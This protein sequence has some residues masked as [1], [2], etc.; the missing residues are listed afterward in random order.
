[1]RLVDDGDGVLMDGLGLYVDLRHRSSG[2]GPHPRGRRVPR[3]AQ[4]A[5]RRC[6]CRRENEDA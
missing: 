5:S 4:R 2:N 6:G 3:L 1:M